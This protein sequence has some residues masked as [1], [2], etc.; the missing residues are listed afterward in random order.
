MLAGTFPNLTGSQIVNLL[1]STADDAGASGTDATFGRGILN[2]GEAFKPQGQTHLAGS[3]KAVSLVENGLSS[4]PI[5]ELRFSPFGGIF[6]VN[7][8]S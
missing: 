5:G 3:D 7:H 2:I 1:M 8:L 6:C 4:G